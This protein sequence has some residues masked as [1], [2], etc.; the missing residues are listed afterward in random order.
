M[1]GPELGTV[2]VAGA[3]KKTGRVDRHRP[4]RIGLALA[5]TIVVANRGRAEA[6]ACAYVAN[7]SSDTVSVIDI[8]TQTVATTMVTGSGLNVAGIA[9]HPHQ[10]LIYVANDRAWTVSAIDRATGGVVATIPMDMAPAALAITPDGLRAYV[11]G[12]AASND[13]FPGAVAIIDLTAH[14]LTGSVPLDQFPDDLAMTPDG[15]RVYVAHFYGRGVSVID[16]ATNAIVASIPIE[17]NPGGLAISPDGELVYVANLSAP[18]IPVISVATN[19][20]VASVSLDPTSYALAISIPK[21]GGFAYA[22]GRATPTFTS[23]I[24]LATNRVT[25]TLPFP[26]S[27][28][29]AHLAVT[30]DGR[31]AYA[32]VVDQTWSSDVGVVDL[33]AGEQVATVAVGDAHDPLV[34]SPDGATAYVGARSGIAA[35]DTQTNSIRAR[36]T[37]EGPRRA[38]LSPDGAT[39]YLLN[40]ISESLAVLDTAEGQITS[41]IPLGKTPVDMAISPDGSS[42]YITLRGPDENGG[43]A[44]FDTVSNT[45]VT[46]IPMGYPGGVA[47]SPDGTTAFV[48]DA[49]RRG[50]AKVDTRTRAVS[51][52]IEAAVA[53]DSD[54]VLTRDGRSG[55]V[56][57]CYS[58]GHS[59]LCV[60]DTVADRIRLVLQPPPPPQV[61]RAHVSLNAERIALSANGSRLYVAGPF[62]DPRLGPPGPMGWGVSVLDVRSNTF[63]SEG[64]VIPDWP[65][66]VAV[67]ADGASVYV[68]SGSFGPGMVTIL[69]TATST[70]TKTLPV[71]S[72]PAAIAIGCTPPPRCAS[73]CDHSSS[74]SIDELVRSVAIQLGRTSLLRCPAADEDGDG[75]VTVN[76]IMSA[77]GTALRG[78]CG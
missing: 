46:T 35:I 54:V 36:I 22:V 30:P 77:V 71:G 58:G 23:E 18:E 73:D 8:E 61:N 37:S 48:T 56:T 27:R 39:A 76:E 68:T 70:I 65:A 49:S 20:I 1:V 53:P 10:D 24:E 50:I 59:G 33:V 13:G 74:V 43:V 75:S 2:L 19:R 62:D 63:L 28:L 55:Y 17:G 47:I 11:S 21:S 60:L 16:T 31:F 25:R 32:N 3:Q 78:W 38:L 29:A 7:R 69:D 42:V 14:A 64:A 4:L 51:A 34:I 57:W 45:V 12:R 67:T 40:E 15:R 6:T 41:R 52:V 9:F 72:E 66:A 26:G 44:I 5:A